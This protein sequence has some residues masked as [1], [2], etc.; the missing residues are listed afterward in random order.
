MFC[1]FV[2]SEKRKK[3]CWM[4]MHGSTSGETCCKVSVLLVMTPVV[5]R[6]SPQCWVHFARGWLL[7]DL[8]ERPC[9]CSWFCM[10]ESG[11]RIKRW[12][13]RLDWGGKEEGGRSVD[14]NTV[15]VTEQFCI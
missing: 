15:Q 11:R 9:T 10:Q 7:V 8:V 6:F 2:E 3:G 14:F 13:L 4:S 1:F 12:L 5:S